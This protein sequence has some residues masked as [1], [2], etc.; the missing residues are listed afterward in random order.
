MRNLSAIV[1][2]Y[3]GQR[4]RFLGLVKQYFGSLCE[5]PRDSRKNCR[6]RENPLRP[7]G[8]IG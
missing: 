2:L 5:E 3:R 4:D 8:A 6:F 7:A 1:W